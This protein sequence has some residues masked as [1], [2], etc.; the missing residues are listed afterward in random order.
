MSEKDKQ[1][2][3]VEAYA[4]VLESVKVNLIRIIKSRAFFLIAVIF[5][6]VLLN[7]AYTDMKIS[8][9][10]YDPSL[11]E[12]FDVRVSMVI[13]YAQDPSKTIYLEQNH[14]L[15]V[16]DEE[17]QMISETYFFEIND[18]SL[19]ASWNSFFMYFQIEEKAFQ[20]F[21][22]I[23]CMFY[24]E[25]KT[26]TYKKANFHKSTEGMAFYILKVDIDRFMWKTD[27][28][29]HVEAKIICSSL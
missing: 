11:A 28:P 27:V 5:V 1:I 26:E 4:V 18:L 12:V 15:I 16:K 29:D 8:Q 14:T 25:N 10:R 20:S 23:R 21:N 7:N 3:T 22:S 24:I 6:T 9:N 13:G 19:T 17:A 2:E